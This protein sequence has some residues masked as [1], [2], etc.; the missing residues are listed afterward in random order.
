MTR[1][2]SS[3]DTSPPGPAQQ[4]PDETDKAFAAFRIYLEQGPKRSTAAVGRACGKHKSLMDRWS[5]RHRWVERVRA[6]E[7]QATALVDGAHLDAVAK[8]SRRQAEIAQLHGEASLTVAREV[9]RRL[10][11]PA[12]ATVEL[13][14]LKIGELLQLE[15]TLGRM[16]GRAVVA[17]RLALGLHTA[18]G[19]EPV[20][21]S[22]AEDVA[23]R[24][25]DDELVAQLAGVDEL[26]PLRERRASRRAAGDA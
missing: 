7:A 23:R 17:E 19:A 1:P 20:P 14:G 3:H 18:Q 11:D 6:F 15:A 9:L 5:S 12:K 21:R 10:A 25:T 24:M 26:A 13:Q 22:M 8:R 2:R 16:H 4:Q